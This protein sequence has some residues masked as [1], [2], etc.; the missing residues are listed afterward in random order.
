[1]SLS[2]TIH[3]GPKKKSGIVQRQ[4]PVGVIVAG[5][6]LSAAALFSWARPAQAEALRLRLFPWTSPEVKAA[7]NRFTADVSQG[8][9]IKEAF[10][11]LLLEIVDDHAG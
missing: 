7:V 10:G 3:Y 8:Q 1:M 9:P 4:K 6:I 2:Y 11:T 5:I